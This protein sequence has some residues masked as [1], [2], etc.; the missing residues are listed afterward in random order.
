MDIVDRLRIPIIDAPHLLATPANVNARMQDAAAEI[1]R[2]RAQVAELEKDAGRYR[3]LI[4]KV[5][6]R[7][8]T[9]LAIYEEFGGAPFKGES[10]P[11]FMD[12]FIDEAMQK[13]AGE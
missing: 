2:L 7:G 1:T 12:R 3:W 6:A 9:T 10:I 8:E 5:F 13:E 11:K 4:G